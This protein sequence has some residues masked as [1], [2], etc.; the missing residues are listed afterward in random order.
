MRRG[1]VWCGGG[2]VLSAVVWCGVWWVVV[3]LDAVWC[4]VARRGVAWCGAG[5]HG[6]VLWLGSMQS[7]DVVCYGV[8]LG[9]SD[10]L[11]ART[12]KK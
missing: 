9:R 11:V 3:G 12:V 6:V 8:K 5:W 7:Y 1:V 10:Q 4:G 2:G